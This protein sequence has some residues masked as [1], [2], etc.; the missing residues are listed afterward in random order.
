MTNTNMHRK[1]FKPCA[2][3]HKGVMHTGLPLFWRVH[4]ERIGVDM[5]AAQRQHGLEQFFG[6]TSP[7]AVALA[8]VFSDGAPIGKPLDEGKTVLVCEDCAMADMPVA[9]LAERGA[10]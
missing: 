7:G 9:V 1:N 6:G 8:D 4:I 2:I 3:C 10:R 5:Q